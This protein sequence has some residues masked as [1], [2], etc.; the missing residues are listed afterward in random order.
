MNYRTSFLALVVLVLGTCFA[1]A[2]AFLD[3]AEPKVG[4]T[5]AASPKVVKIW[6]TQKLEIAFS[7]VQVFDEAGN[8]V[9]KRDKKLDPSDQSLLLVSVPQLKPG[10]Y[11]VSW[12]VVSVD[13]HV[14]SG[15]FTFEI[16]P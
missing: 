9:D 3:H 1:Q 13:T 14:T 11:K 12:R 7:N 2:H 6:F 8:Q 15:T 5:V 10:K 16:S 4:S